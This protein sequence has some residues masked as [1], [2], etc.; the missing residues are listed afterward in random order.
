MPGI[1]IVSPNCAKALD[2][3]SGFCVVY[4]HGQNIIWARLQYRMELTEIRS[5]YATEAVEPDL[6]A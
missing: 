4:G 5:L 2:V 3:T 6:G 1:V